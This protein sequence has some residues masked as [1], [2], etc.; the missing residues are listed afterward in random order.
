[1]QNKTPEKSTSTIAY[2]YLLITFVL[3]GSLYVVS[4]YVLGKLPTFTISFIRFLLAFLFLTLVEKIGNGSS[5][6]GNRKGASGKGTASD[7]TVSTKKKKL[8]PGHFRYIVL[9]GFGGYFIAVGAQLLGTKYAGASTASLLNSMNPV[10]MA[11]FGALI[12]GEKLTVRK[13]IGLVLSIAGVFAVLGGGFQGAGMAGVLLSLFSVL[14]WSYISVMT[15]KI[16]QEYEPLLISRLACGVAAVCYL[17]VAIG[18]AVITK[19]P[20][21]TVF[22]SD[23]SCTLALLYM[24]IVCTGVAYTLWNKSLSLLDAGV[25]SAFYPVQPAV[26]T[27]LGILLLGE[28]VTTGFVIGSVLIVCGVLISLV[29]GKKE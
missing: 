29:H 3:W 24:G 18:E 19:A 4:K 17:P 25:C 7:P 13:V 11:L 23:L 28:S 8:A 27:L 1:M 20:V 9:V 15:R 26:S 10:T 14:F 16:T 5:A 12:L 22:T 6:S 21:L 2:F